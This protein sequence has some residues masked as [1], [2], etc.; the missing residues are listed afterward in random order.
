MKQEIN[1]EELI[2]LKIRF[3]ENAIAFLMQSSH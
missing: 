1:C 3:E 2:K